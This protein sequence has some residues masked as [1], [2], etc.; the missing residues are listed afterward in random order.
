MHK[1][2]FVFLQSVW[3]GTVWHKRFL[4]RGVNKVH[5]AKKLTGCQVVASGCRGKSK[6]VPSLMSPNHYYYCCCCCYFLIT[7]GSV[8][9]RGFFTT[10]WPFVPWHLQNRARWFC[11]TLPSWFESTGSSE[12]NPAWHG[13]VWFWHL[14]LPCKPLLLGWFW[15][16]SPSSQWITGRWWCS[17]LRAPATLPAHCSSPWEPAPGTGGAC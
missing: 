15:D 12:A 14:S 16:F 4:W 7:R 13:G 17:A 3:F 2:T 1:N 6:L 8:Q 9:R 11:A 5:R 10:T